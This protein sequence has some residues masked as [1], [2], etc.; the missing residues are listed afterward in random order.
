MATSVILLIKRFTSK[1]SYTQQYRE[2][3]YSRQWNVRDL[4]LLQYYSKKNVFNNSIEN[5]IT[6]DS[7]M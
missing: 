4:D 6:A 2:Q 3:N 7:G 1:L 5:K